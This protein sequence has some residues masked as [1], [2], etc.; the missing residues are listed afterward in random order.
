MSLGLELFGDQWTLLI[1]RD[2]LYKKKCT[3]KDFSSSQEHISSA[4]LADRLSKLEKADFLSKT[5]HPTNKK[6][7]VYELKQKGLDLAP[8]IAEY[9]NWGYTYL[10]EHIS[11]KSKRIVEEFR[12]NPTEVL[13]KF[14]NK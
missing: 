9:M 3:F 13:N 6:V 10:N 8:I 1:I 7:Y 14:K 5:Q 11:E 12:A 4:R 2:L